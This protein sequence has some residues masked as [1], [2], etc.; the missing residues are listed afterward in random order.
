MVGGFLF[1]ARYLAGL[2]RSVLKPPVAAAGV[3]LS[4]SSD[5]F[6][7]LGVIARPLY[8]ALRF[9]HVH[10]IPN[11]GWD[12]VALT[13][14][15]NVVVLWPRIAAMKS[16]LKM[17]RLQP[18]V[19]AIKERYAHLAI[20]DPA[21]AE[22]NAEMMALYKAE[23][24]NMFGGCLPTLLQMPLLFAYLRVLR[25]AQ[26][27][28]GA[29]WLW[30]RDLSLPDP[31]HILPMLIIASMVVTQMVTPAPGMTSSQRWAM[32]VLMPVVMGFSLWHYAAGLSLYW[33]TG[34]FIGLLMQVVI[35][36]SAMGREI[37]AQAA[38]RR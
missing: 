27:L 15:F 8:L 29:H 20:A 18:Q 37:R 22:M 2:T 33:L 21:R 19:D 11:W 5:S 25:G 12:I 7:W 26:E 35:N 24:A 14:M 9:L 6:G 3:R 1:G 13:V 17:M 10:G 34:N 32:G 36:R 30:L 38:R 23:G 28:H 4:A 31:L 16:S